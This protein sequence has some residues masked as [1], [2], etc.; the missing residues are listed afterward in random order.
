MSNKKPRTCDLYTPFEEGSAS[1]W[2]REYPRPQMKRD[3]YVSLCGEWELYVKKDGS[4][5]PLGGIRVP[6]VPESRL[7]GICRELAEGE[8]YIY[9]RTFVTDEINGRLLL[10]FGAV[11]QIAAVWV[12]G[13]LAGEHIGGYL[14][15]TLDITELVTA[16][17]N[18]LCV[19]VTDALDIELPYGKQC[20]KRG[21]MW[22]TPISGIWQPVWLEEV[23]KNYI[24]SL[25]ITPA[26]DR[27]TIETKGGNAEKR[28]I[29]HTDAGEREYSYTGDSITVEV[30]YPRLWTPEEPYLYEFTLSDGED[31]IDSYFALRTV[32][33]ETRA[34]QSYICLNG[35][36]YFFH[37]LLDQGYFSDGIYL[38]ASPEG[39]AWDIRTMKALGFNTL[40]KHIKTEPDIFYYYCDKYGMI[41]FQDMVNSGKYHYFID[42]VLPNIGIK[43]GFTHH[44]TEQ[45]RDRFESDSRETADLLYNHPCVCYYTIFN[46]G[47]GQY[48]AD[49]IYRM[50]KEHDPSRIW[51]STSGWFVEK[52]SDVVSDHVYFKRISPKP[53]TARPIVLS[54]FGGYSCRIDG[55]SFNLDKNYGYRTY[56]TVEEFTRGLEELYR[57]EIIPAIGKGLCAAILT[58]VS[59]IEDETNGLCTYDRRVVKAD[60]K[61][62]QALSRDLVAAFKAKIGE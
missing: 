45:R 53:N 24:S 26:L 12:N 55:H 54:E 42:T 11:D 25:R 10:H 30:D 37:G 6:F 22:Y 3:S 18:S 49:R 61:K 9:R 51:D 48:D 46:E 39:F 56:N 20:K 23:A 29:L 7:S 17:E 40:R 15:F 4:E 57:G 13:R 62:M 21:G 14:P 36:P 5:T 32:S 28:L 43:R 50:L 1:S 19:E 34:G 8:Q 60:L 33:I 31:K 58:Q 52:E 41:V 47:W 2:E 27:V 38:P 35:E 44:A 59:D 16:G